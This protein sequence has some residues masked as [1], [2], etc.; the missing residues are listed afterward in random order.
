M[1]SFFIDG[2]DVD[3]IAP[4]ERKE[5]IITVQSNVSAN[6]AINIQTGAGAGPGSLD[7]DTDIELPDSGAEFESDERVTIDLNGVGQDK[8]ASAATND[9]VYWV[10]TTE[11]AFEIGLEATDKITVRAPRKC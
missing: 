4:V 11:I 10:S 8:G 2:Q 3:K 9:D 5:M 6:T 1:G 7:G